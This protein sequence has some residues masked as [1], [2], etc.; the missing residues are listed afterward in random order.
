MANNIDVIFFD[1]GGTLRI[2]HPDPPYQDRAIRR[3]AELAGTDMEPYAFLQLCDE[4]Y[5]PYRAEIFQT[6]REATEQEMWTRWMLPEYDRER[7]AK[8]AVEM[9]LQYR[10]AKGHRHLVEHGRETIEALH[11][12]GYRLGIISNLITSR[13]VPDWLEKDG[14]AQYFHPVLLSAVIG[15]RKPD[16]EIYWMACRELDTPPERCASVADNL[17]RDFTG[18]K[19]AGIGMNILF[20]PAEKYE[21]KKASITDENRPDAVIHDFLELLELFPAAPEMNESAVRRE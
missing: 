12:R 20:M 2:L 15:L 18:G 5:E 16:P 11:A 14:L 3:L 9:S 8:N 21:K 19:A 17:N 4:R 1:L 7:L 10:M 6:N 13:E